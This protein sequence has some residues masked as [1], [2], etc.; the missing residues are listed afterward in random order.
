[1]LQT[2]KDRLAGVAAV[3]Y[4]AAVAWWRRWRDY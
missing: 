2:I 3:I 4:M 1:M